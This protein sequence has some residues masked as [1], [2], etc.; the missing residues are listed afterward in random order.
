MKT[1]DEMLEE[2]ARMHHH[3][4]PRQV[5]GVRMGILAGKILNLD[6]PQAGKRLL[7]IAETDGCAVDGISVATNCWVGRRTLR[8]EDYG[9]IAATFVDTVMKDAFRIA[10]RRTIREYAREYAPMGS[11]KWTAQLIGYQRMSDDQLL[12]VQEVELTV[13]LEKIISRPGKKAICQKCGEEIM[14]EREIAREGRIVCRA[15]GENA[16][17]RTREGIYSSESI[18]CQIP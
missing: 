16:Y 13:P 17:Y 10:P 2:T 7:A 12:L 9:K 4:C 6:L 15:C 8:I 5:L 14:N 11:T 3:L 18:R 1:L